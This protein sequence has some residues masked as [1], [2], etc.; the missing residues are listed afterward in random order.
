MIDAIEDGVV[1]DPETMHRYLGEARRAVDI[2]VVLVDDLFELAALDAGAIAAEDERARLADVRSAL[3][4]CQAQAT[5][6]GVAVRSDLNGAGESAC[7]PRLVRVLQNLI[8]NAIRHT[9][10]DGS[11]RVEARTA[12]PFLEITVTDSGEGISQDSLARIFDPFWR[13][14]AARTTPAGLGLALAKRI[15]EALGGEIGVR[16]TPAV[17]SR[18]TVRLPL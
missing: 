15:V 3:A 16:S 4:A 8:Q 13:G 6:K 9:P 7:S 12:E 17:G 11:I 1:G 5:A 10:S 14:D 18:F 2:L